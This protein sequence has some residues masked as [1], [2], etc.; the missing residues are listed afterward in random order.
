MI[1]FPSENRHCSD[2]LGLEFGG[3]ERIHNPLELEFVVAGVGDR[4]VIAEMLKSLMA[5]SLGGAEAL[6]WLVSAPPIT[7]KGLTPSVRP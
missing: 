5:P 7:D 4:G 6:T 1:Q 3:G 2:P